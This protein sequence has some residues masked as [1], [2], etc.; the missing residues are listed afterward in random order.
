MPGETSPVKAPC[1]SGWTFWA[2]R[3]TADPSR[4]RP[5]RSRTVKGTAS[6][7]STRPIVSTRGRKLR[8][9]KAFASP[10]SC[11]SSSSRR[12]SGDASQRSRASTPGSARPCTYSSEA[13]P[14]VERWSIRRTEAEVVDG[15]QRVAAAHHAG[16][17]RAG[18][19]VGHRFRTRRERLGLEDAHGSVPEDG[20]G[21]AGLAGVAPRSRGRCRRRS[22]RRGSPAR[23]VRSRSGLQRS[24]TR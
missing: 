1:S 5:T 22:S 8:A 16:G 17:L 9:T 12:G 18:D 11:A 6:T 14:P 19:A 20:L 7:I 4:L 13:P 23:P 21:V 2:A 24:A 10:R 15:R 3:C